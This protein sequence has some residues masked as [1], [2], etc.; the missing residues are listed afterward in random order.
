MLITRIDLG[1]DSD[2]RTTFNA[3]V[4]AVIVVGVVMMELIL[5]KWIETV[6]TRELVIK[7]I[8]P[9]DE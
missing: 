1:G 9:A 8:P 3:S 2:V 5:Y 4:K 7:I 6:Y